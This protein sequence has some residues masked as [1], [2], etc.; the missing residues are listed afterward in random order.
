MKKT[1]QILMLSVA[2]LTMGALLAACGSSDSSSDPAVQVSDAW[3]RTTAP[4]QTEGAVYMTIESADGDRLVGA[5]VPASVAAKAEI[6][7]SMEKSGET[8][9]S[10]EGMESGDTAAGGGEDHGMMTMKEVGEV[11][12]PAGETVKLEP[13]GF[14]IMLMHLKG[15]IEAGETIPVTL[16]FEKDGTVKVDATAKDE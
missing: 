15:P 3:A 9:D 11:E 13:G 5:Q 12:I 4:T 7:E 16:D 14:H 10:E 6:H 8:G 2:V 1:R